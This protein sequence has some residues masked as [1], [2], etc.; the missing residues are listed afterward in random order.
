MSEYSIFTSGSVSEG[1]PDKIADQFSDACLDAIIAEDKYARGVG[2][3][4]VDG[5]YYCYLELS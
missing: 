1:Y 4:V 2:E 5:R 3:T